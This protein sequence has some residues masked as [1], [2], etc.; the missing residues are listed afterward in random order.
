MR[1]TIIVIIVVAACAAAGFAQTATV[2]LQNQEN[3][4]FYYVV[5]PPDLADL[6]AGSPLLASRVASFFSSKSAEPA[7]SQIDP[8]GEASLDGLQDGSHLLVGF[9]AVQDLDQFP[10]RVMSVQADSRVGERFYVLFASPSQLTVPRGTGRLASF[11]GLAVQ[12]AAG[13]QGSSPAADQGTATQ[14][15]A[16]STATN[17]AAG[18]RQATP[19]AQAATATQAA[20]TPGGAA[21]QTGTSQGAAAATAGAEPTLP[22][23]AVFSARYDPV[24][25]TKETQGTFSVLPVAESRAWELTGTRITEVDGQVSAG[26]L[27]LA[28]TVPGGF[29]EKVSYFLYV[30]TDRSVGST[31]ALTLEIEPRASGSRG[32]CILWTRGRD[33][34]SLVG[35]VQSAGDTVELTLPSQAAAGAQASDALPDLAA[36]FSSSSSFDLTAGWYDRALGTWEEFYYATI[37]VADIPTADAPGAAAPTR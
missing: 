31:N 24:V 18:P 19:A 12:Q 2:S 17:Q 25:F 15:T 6:T 30:F 28:L 11:P 21:T 5:D 7:F 35:D 1:R 29:S 13:T 20:T 32:A 4:P 34:P 22:S 14:Q 33:K 9:F 36:L 37:A 10:V 8:G 27:R 23:V 26:T 3:A 16:G